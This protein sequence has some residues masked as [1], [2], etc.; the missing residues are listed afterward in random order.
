MDRLRHKYL[1]GNSGIWGVGVHHINILSERGDMASA[2]AA[3]QVGEW[4]FADGSVYTGGMTVKD[5]GV[6]VREGQGTFVDVSA[7]ST[8]VGLWQSDTMHGQGKIRLSGGSVYDG[9]CVALRCVALRALRW[10]APPPKS[11]RRRVAVPVAVSVVCVWC[12]CVGV[13]V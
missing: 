10:S 4:R 13:V 2:G 3:V 1:L 12:V 7:G 6:G 5:G 8:Y 11:K 9:K